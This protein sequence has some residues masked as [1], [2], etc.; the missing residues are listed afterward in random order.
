[1]FKN[2]EAEM[3]RKGISRDDIAHLLNQSYNT[4]G[5]KLR[6]DSKFLFDEA[7]AI[8]EKFFPEFDLE[9]LFVKENK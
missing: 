1:M 4:I 8:K 5:N 2:L 9:Y 6:G 7:Y 3:V